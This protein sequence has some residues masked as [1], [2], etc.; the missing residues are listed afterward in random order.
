M[1]KGHGREIRIK[2]YCFP[3]PCLLTSG[4]YRARRRQLQHLQRTFHRN[5]PC[6]TEECSLR[7]P[8]LF[9]HTG[10]WPEG[11]SSRPL[12]PSVAVPLLQVNKFHTAPFAD[13]GIQKPA[14]QSDN[15]GSKYGRPETVYIESGNNARCHLEHKC[16][17]NKGEKAQAQDID[18]QG[19]NKKNGPK[20]HI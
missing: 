1:K 4:Q 19:Q 6:G 13:E 12:F 16:I 7:N 10:A 2:E 8:L 18:G 11:D 15:E 14:Y 20:K 9:Q 3:C 17:N 5:P